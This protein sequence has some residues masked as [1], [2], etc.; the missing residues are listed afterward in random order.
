MLAGPLFGAG[1]IIDLNL[2]IHAAPGHKYA[3]L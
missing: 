3:I 2:V 1:I